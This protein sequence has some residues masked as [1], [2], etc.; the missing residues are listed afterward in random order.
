MARELVKESFA[1]KGM[2]CAAC[3]TSLESMLKT[4]NGITNVSVNYP[5]ESVYIEYDTEEIDLLN[6]QKAAKGI[7]Y[8]V[9]QESEYDGQTELTKRLKKLRHKLSVSIILTLPIFVISMFLMGS[10]PFEHYLLLGLSIPVIVWSGAEFYINAAK[11]ARHFSTNM[12]TLVALSTGSAFL[13]SAF[14][15]FFPDYLTNI[16]LESHVYYESATVIISLILLG[17]YLEERAKFRTTNAINKLMGIQP[18]LVNIIE[19][20]KIFTLPIKD[21]IKKQVF[22]VKPGEKIPLD[23][24]IVKGSSHIDESAINGEPLPLTR[25]PGDYVYAGTVNQN[26]IL[27]IEIV[28]V[29]GETLLSQI[30]DLVKKAQASKPPIQKIVD[31]ISSIFVPSVIVISLIAFFAW[32]ILGPEPA[33]SY[34]FTIMITVLIIACPCALG[35]ATPTA[36]MVGIGRGAELGILIKNAE[37][38][39]WAHK[40]NTLVLD[41]TGTITI[42]KPEVVES[43]WADSEHIEEQKAILAFIESKSEHPLGRAISDHLKKYQTWSDE[44]DFTNLPGKGIL[45]KINGHRYLVGS[46]DLMKE[47]NVIIPDEML[48]KVHASYR[49]MSFYAKDKVLLG[50]MSIDDQLRQGAGEAILELQ[51]QGIDV[52]LLSGDN[53]DVTSRIAS[54]VGIINFKGGVLP[55][56]KGLYIENLQKQNK[57]VGMVGDGINDSHALAQADIGIALG[58]GTD[59][60]M[61][62]AGITLMKP[63]IHSI[64]HAIMLSKATVKTINENLFWAFGYNILM[65]PVAAGALYPVFGFLLNPMIAGA[66]MAFS[67]VSVVTNSLRLKR[68]KI[69]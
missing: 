22:I 34:A 13:Y 44:I 53:V 67:S 29:A 40:I 21:A 36:L 46:A 28:K 60:A 37:S 16:G 18:K 64:K 26:G 50:I 57:T 1:V 39:E 2:T 8:S 30:I 10:I 25:K 59:I 12:D 52:H 20:G 51:H 33:F 35:L 19:Q 42:G 62:S 45:A 66:T 7:G 31:K 4:K 69:I 63:D 27:E 65:I 3:A 9:L 6:I 5:N 58:T 61:E 56:E 11:K 24:V 55:N 48:N 68:K 41:K 17:R 54:E 32:Y 49:S 23:G 43:H 15:T 38:L 47:Y 14:N